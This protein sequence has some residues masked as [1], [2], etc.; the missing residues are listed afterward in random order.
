MLCG[1][2]VSVHACLWVRPSVPSVRVAPARRAAVSLRCL[3][4]S[5]RTPTLSRYIVDIRPLT[6]LHPLIHNMVS[7]ERALRWCRRDARTYSSERAQPSLENC[8]TLGCCGAKPRLVP[9]SFFFF[10][11]PW[12]VAPLPSSLSLPGAHSGN[13]TKERWLKTSEKCH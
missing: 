6:S 8:T 9:F 10:F 4:H 13:M 5:T 11:S 1:V 7:A 12:T 2:C 3:L